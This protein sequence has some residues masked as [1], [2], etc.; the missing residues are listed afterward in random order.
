MKTDFVELTT[1]AASGVSS[2]GGPDP[3][4]RVIDHGSVLGGAGHVPSAFH[5]FSVHERLDAV[6]LSEGIADGDVV[7][8][9]V[10]A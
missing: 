10:V 1:E 4:G 2:H 7:P 3:D 8:A 6:G 5:G 9:I